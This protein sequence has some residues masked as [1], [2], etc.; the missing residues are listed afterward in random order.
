MVLP[1]FLVDA[2]KELENNSTC[3]SNDGERGLLV[4]LNY[5][6][7]MNRDQFE[8][9]GGLP[10]VWI[11]FAYFVFLVTIVLVN[12]LN[13]LVFY[14][15]IEDIQLQVVCIPL[16]YK[17]GIDI[18]F[19]RIF[20]IYM[21]VQTYSNKCQVNSLATQEFILLPGNSS[22]KLECWSPIAGIFCR[23]S[24]IT[25]AKLEK[26]NRFIQY[27]YKRVFLFCSNFPEKTSITFDHSGRIQSSDELMV[28]N[29]LF[30]SSY[31]INI[32]LINIIC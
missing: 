24:P 4:Y 31:T 11:V 27:I 21:Q 28:I 16:L 1:I 5:F 25:S 7:S 19:F 20:C 22:L 9:Y 32:S 26:C 30:K 18:F 14:Y 10:F 15:D 17:N 13:G 29:L 2:A 6:S 8:H 12:S 3:N 23:F